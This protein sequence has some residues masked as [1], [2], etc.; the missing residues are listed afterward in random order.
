MAT[1]EDLYYMYMGWFF[2]CLTGIG[3]PIWAVLIGDL[4]DAFGP[5]DPEA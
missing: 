1:K 3:M 5:G 4:F 2:A